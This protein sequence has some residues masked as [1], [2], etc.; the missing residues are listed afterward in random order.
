M[1]QQ[2]LPDPLVPAEVD[3]RD[4]MPPRSMLIELCVNTFGITVEEAEELL[5]TIGPYWPTTGARQ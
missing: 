2:P 4:T 1:Q 3:L 5:D